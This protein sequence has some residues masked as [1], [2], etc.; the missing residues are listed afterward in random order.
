MMKNTERATRSRMRKLYGITLE[1][2]DAMI[3]KQN[4]RC[5]VCLREFYTAIGTEPHTDHDHDSGWVRGIAC[6]NCNHALGS[7]HDDVDVMQRAIEYLISNAT[8]TEFNIHIAREKI[9][10]RKKAWNRGKSWD[11]ITRQKMSESAKKRMQTE[12]GKQHLLRMWGKKE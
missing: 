4:N 12:E 7:F 3:V 5:P 2:R 9:R 11:E 1:E 8:P 6:E 10:R